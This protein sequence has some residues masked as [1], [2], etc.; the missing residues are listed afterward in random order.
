[1]DLDK[2]FVR[3]A[4]LLG[5]LDTDEGVALLAQADAGRA[6]IIGRHL[7]R[8]DQ[9]S[10]DQVLEIYRHVGYIPC[11]RC[12]HTVNL[13][14]DNILKCA[15]CKRKFRL[16]ANQSADHVGKTVGA[17]QITA[18][19]GQGGMGDLYEAV[20]AGLDKKFALKV[21]APECVRNVSFLERFRREARIAA[22]VDHPNTIGIIT[23][24][25]E[26]GLHYIVMPLVDGQDLAHFVDKNG[27]FD[28]KEGL[29]ILIQMARGLEAIHKAG[30]LHRDVK[31]DNVL[32]DSSGRVLLG[33]FGLAREAMGASLT[34][35]GVILGTPQYMS[36]EQCDGSD[37]DHRSDIYNLGVTYYY[38]LHGDPPFDDESPMAVMLKQK[39]QPLPIAAEVARAAGK[40]QIHVLARMTAKNPEDRYQ[41]VS[42][43]LSDLWAL[44]EG[45]RIGRKAL[46]WNGG[47]RRMWPCAA[48]V[49]LI[50]GLAIGFNHGGMRSGTADPPAPRDVIQPAPERETFE[51][52]VARYFGGQATIVDA[53]RRRIR[54][55]VDRSNVGTLDS[56]AD[57]QRVKADMS[58]PEKLEFTSISSESSFS[59][60]L[61]AQFVGSL[62]YEA[63]GRFKSNAVG[64]SL[65]FRLFRQLVRG[66]DRSLFLGLQRSDEALTLYYQNSWPGTLGP[67]KERGPEATLEQ[68]RFLLVGWSR[69]GTYRIDLGRG[70]TAPTATIG[71]PRKKLMGTLGLEARHFTMFEL[72]HLVCEGNLDEDWVRSRLK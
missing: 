6:G 15:A 5:H 22:M 65:G 45:R 18:K 64:A 46:R 12:S 38:L 8:T 42:E 66:A 16:P 14:D 49:A 57:W 58:D 47:R 71:G 9:L 52:F 68:D 51:A 11:P 7:V 53:A 21:I 28:P 30:I 69:S 56:V 70:V 34:Q 32:V 3:Y 29:S 25:Q 1:M 48:L 24:G 63:S 62:K 40:Q 19:I 26:N 54:I 23:V 33:D 44:E 55:S 10:R 43:L 31:P 27:P 36:P 20:H 61:K 17:Y 59:L 13:A 2:E 37:V 35:T 67:V 41:T 50:A 72:E 4:V 60:Q 39:T